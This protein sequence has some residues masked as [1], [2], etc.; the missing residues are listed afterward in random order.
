MNI[1]LPLFYFSL[2]THTHTHTHTYIH[3]HT[4]FFTYIHFSLLNLSFFTKPLENNLHKDTT[5]LNTSAVSPR[6][7]SFSY[8]ANY[9]YNYHY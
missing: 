8:T 1:V 7:W 3:T 2:H 5:S 4:L 9:Y 6:N